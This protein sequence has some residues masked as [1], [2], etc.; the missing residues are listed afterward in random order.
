[1]SILLTKLEVH[2]EK[3]CAQ[4]FECLARLMA[5]GHTQDQGSYS[6]P[7]TAVSPYRMTKSNFFLTVGFLFPV[8]QWKKFWIMVFKAGTLMTNQSNSRI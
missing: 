1:M 2:V 8:W 6:R 3:I 5:E 7:S 4:G